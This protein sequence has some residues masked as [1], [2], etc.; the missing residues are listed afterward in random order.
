MLNIA[1]IYFVYATAYD[2]HN[3]NHF[4]HGERILHGHTQIHTVTIDA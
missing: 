1:L 3:R 4:S 2:N